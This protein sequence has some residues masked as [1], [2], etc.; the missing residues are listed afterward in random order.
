MDFAVTY[1][2]LETL[3]YLH[4]KGVPWTDNTCSKLIYRANLDML[5]YAHENGAQWAQPINITAY[6]HLALGCLEYALAN[7]CPWDPE[8]SQRLAHWCKDKKILELYTRMSAKK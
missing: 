7:G 6:N 8:L 5:K 1:G 4:E 2:S 3:Q